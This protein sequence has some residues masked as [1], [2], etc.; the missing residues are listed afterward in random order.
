[1]IQPLYIVD[2]PEEDILDGLLIIYH[3]WGLPVGYNK[4]WWDYLA[5]D[6]YQNGNIGEA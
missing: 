4:V 1:M 2:V 6:Y 3:H 5:W